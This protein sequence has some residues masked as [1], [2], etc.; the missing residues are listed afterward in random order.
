MTHTGEASGAD[1]AAFA[2]A[3]APLA[4]RGVLGAVLLQYPGSF[5]HGP[6]ASRRVL[7]LA[8]RLRPYP[9]VAEFRHR[10]WFR[11]ETYALLRAE[12]SASAVWTNRHS[13]PAAAGGRRHVRTA[14]VRFHGRN[15]E[16]WHRHERPH[17]RYDYLYSRE[18]LAAWVPRIRALDAA[19]ARTLV[20]MN[21]HYEAKAVTNARQL[22]E[23]LATGQPGHSGGPD[24][25]LRRC[26][27]RCL[28]GVLQHASR[29]RP[30]AALPGR[31]M[32]LPTGSGS[33]WYGGP[34]HSG[35]PDPSGRQHPSARSV[36][37]L[38]KP[39]TR[40]TIRQA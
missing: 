21:N 3:L 12:G 6:G 9:V 29:A 23:L 4:E 36:P 39:P 27:S 20:F 25:P 7:T 28:C 8:G 31:I 2:A 1:L 16:H 19:A 14:Y 34:G 17:E 5:L 13:G 35:G 37:R 30:T 40:T 18:E 15:A 32:T 38:R 26:R 33:K 11:E 10:S 24:P 22:K